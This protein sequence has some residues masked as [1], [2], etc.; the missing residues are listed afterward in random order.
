MVTTPGSRTHVPAGSPAQALAALLAGN[1]RFARGEPW[2]GH[3]VLAAAAASGD[4]DPFAVVL[5]CI[6]SRVPLE[7]VFDQDFGAICVVRSGGHVLD[8]AVLGSV[9]F[10]VAELG[11]ALV[12][13]LG[14]QRCG[15]VQATVDAVR[16][17]V[18]P[19]GPV[20]FLVDAITP[21]VREVAGGP[22][23]E[24]PVADPAVPAV[25]RAHVRRTV[26]ALQRLDRLRGGV[27]AGAVAVVGAVY[28]L[29]SGTVALLS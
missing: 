12:M 4:Q 8:R 11:A 18:R 29:D 21:A 28:D 9:E 2:Y 13:V 3:H 16:A 27:A 14:H 25:T 19:A 15:A 22:E 26:A 23:A 10:A 1:Q 5:G 17:G 6:D 24:Q 20:G 7:A